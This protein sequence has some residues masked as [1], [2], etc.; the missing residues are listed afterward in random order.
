[1]ADVD[2]DLEATRLV[3]DAMRARERANVHRFAAIE[4][5]MAALEARLAA[6]Q[7]AEMDFLDYSVRTVYGRSALSRTGAP[8]EQP[9]DA[10]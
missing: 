1:M 7:V 9:R 5:R 4:Q 2:G 10:E 6:A 8:L 3:V